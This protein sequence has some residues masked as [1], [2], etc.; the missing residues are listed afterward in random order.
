[1]LVVNFVL[2]P[3]LVGGG[4]L[5]VEEASREHVRGV[6]RLVLQRRVQVGGKEDATHPPGEGADVWN[7]TI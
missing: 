5:R 1:L 6:V 3:P 7:A 2:P 4:R